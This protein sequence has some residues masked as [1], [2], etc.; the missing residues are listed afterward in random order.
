MKFPPDS[1]RR[2]APLIGRELSE[3]PWYQADVMQRLFDSMVEHPPTERSGG[4]YFN[5]S[6]GPWPNVVM[7]TNV[8]GYSL[9]CT[10][11]AKFIL[12]VV[13]VSTKVL[14]TIAKMAPA[15]CCTKT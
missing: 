13:I 4:R 5:V 3:Q 12:S 11:N 10:T 1:R 6:A 15:E 9:N 7:A 14:E 2:I 8:T